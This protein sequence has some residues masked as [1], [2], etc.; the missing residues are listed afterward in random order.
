MNKKGCIL[1]I[2]LLCVLSSCK[3]KFDIPEKKMVSI[4]VD[5][6]VADGVI[7]ARSVSFD[8]VEVMDS[9]L[10]YRPILEK[11]GYTP[12]DFRNALNQYMKNPKALE[13]VYNKVI[14]QLKESQK[15]YASAAN[16]IEGEDINQD[17]V[18]EQMESLLYYKTS[19]VGDTIMV[20]W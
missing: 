13:D 8:M 11:Y 3:V 19:V 20:W 14:K 17:R 12:D 2:F 4:L 18:Q 5:M 6:H 16:I 1:A 15:L 9:S 7:A 10:L